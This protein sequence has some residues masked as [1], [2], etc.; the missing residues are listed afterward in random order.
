MGRDQ[1][2]D[3]RLNSLRWCPRRALSLSIYKSSRFMNLLMVHFLKTFCILCTH[4]TQLILNIFLIIAT[5][6]IYWSVL[7]QLLIRILVEVAIIHLPQTKL[8]FLC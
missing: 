8:P 5:L 3:A 4:L 2:Q 7:I 1:F 6:L